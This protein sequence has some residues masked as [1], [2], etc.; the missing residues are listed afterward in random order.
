MPNWTKFDFQGSK[1]KSRTPKI[2]SQRSKLE[3]RKPKSDSQRSNC[4]VGRSR[5]REQIALTR[6]AALT[7]NKFFYTRHE[8][9]C[10]ETSFFHPPRN[11]LPRNEFFFFCHETSCHETRF[12]TRHKTSCHETKYFNPPRNDFFKAPRNELPR[13]E[14]FVFATKRVPRN[15]LFFGATKRVAT[16]QVETRGQN[17][18]LLCTLHLLHGISICAHNQC[19]RAHKSPRKFSFL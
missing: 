1:I 16:K 2:N 6:A 9:S 4:S 15:E 14:F 8:T 10:H 12:L 3:S 13:N 5:V 18:Y 11:K 17:G 19:T 7:R